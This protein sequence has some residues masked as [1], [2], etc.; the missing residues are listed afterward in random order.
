MYIYKLPNTIQN[1][2]LGMDEFAIR[3]TFAGS[4]HEAIGAALSPESNGRY[5]EGY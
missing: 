3:Q 1:R 5:Q 4:V 2:P